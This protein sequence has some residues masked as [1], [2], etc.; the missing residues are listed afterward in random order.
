M[1][2]LMAVDDIQRE[3]ILIPTTI[4]DIIRRL[5]LFVRDFYYLI[6]FVRR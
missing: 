4:Y 3:L 5:S 1:L 2:Q 6:A